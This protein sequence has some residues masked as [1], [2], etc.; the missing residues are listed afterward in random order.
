MSNGIGLNKKML[1]AYMKMLTADIPMTG[2]DT[3]DVEGWIC[4]VLSVY[5]D[6]IKDGGWSDAQIYFHETATEFWYFGNQDWI[7]WI[8]AIPG[9]RDV[10][11][12]IDGLLYYAVTGKTDALTAPRRII[13]EVIHRGIVPQ[14]VAQVCA[15]PKKIG[16]SGS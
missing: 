8:K 15:L 9:I 5:A 16:G 12:F 3:V 14:G 11:R 6:D 4:E 2:L 10:G 1:Q 7:E 13:P